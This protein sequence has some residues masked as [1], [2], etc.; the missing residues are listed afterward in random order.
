MWGGGE[1]VL[2]QILTFPGSQIP[3]EC[4][5]V[6]SVLSTQ[7]W[8]IVFNLSIAPFK[9]M[10]QIS[11]EAWP[12]IQRRGSILAWT[13]ILSVYGADTI[14]EVKLLISPLLH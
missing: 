13:V 5:P 11:L 3:K 8:R 12:A 10:V 2:K 7:S 6:V 4:A 9:L 14:T 1:R